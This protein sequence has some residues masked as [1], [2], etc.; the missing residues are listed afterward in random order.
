MKKLLILL[1]GAGSAAMAAQTLSQLIESAQQNDL[2]RAYVQRETSAALNRDA[3]RAGY[4]PRI[5]LGGSAGFVD[6]KGTMDVGE[7]YVGY[8]KASVVVFDGFKRENALDELRERMAARSFDLSGYKKS[9]ALEVTQAYFNLQSVRGD[10][11]AQEQSKKQLE[12][13][14]SRQKRFLEAHIVTDEAVA[15]IEAALANAAYDI[16]ELRYREDELMATLKMLS[17]VNVEGVEPATLRLPHEEAPIE[18]DAIAA[19]RHNALATRY[20]AEQQ[21]AHYYPTLMVEDTYSFYDYQNYTDTFP[22]ERVDKQNRL[23]VVATMNLFDFFSASKAK[24]SVMAQKYA[25]DAQI[26]Y[27][28]KRVDTNIALSRKGIARAE[29]LMEAAEAALR[30][31]ERTFETVEKKYHANIVDYVKYLDALYQKSK[32]QAQYTRA[33]NAMQLAYALYI[34]H[35]GFDIKEYVK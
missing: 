16:A 2:V 35:A 19:L 11:A 12:E 8:A 30:A 1:I 34:Y 24:E 17:G 7:T 21:N 29:A 31:S 23:Q 5:D 18:N 10:I 26:A 4:M 25:L 9:V 22:I 3:L 28:S 6:E 15:R 14:L 32:A 27:E 20:A 33:Q 13:E